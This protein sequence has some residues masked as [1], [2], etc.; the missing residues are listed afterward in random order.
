MRKLQSQ[1]AAQSNVADEQQMKGWCKNVCCKSEQTALWTHSLRPLFSLAIIFTPFISFLLP[2]WLCLYVLSQFFIFFRWFSN[3]FPDRARN[4]QPHQKCHSFPDLFSYFYCFLRYFCFFFLNFPFSTFLCVFLFRDF[5]RRCWATASRCHYLHELYM[6]IW[7]S[8]FTLQNI[9]ICCFSLNESIVWLPTTDS[10]P[11][12]VLR[13]ATLCWR[14]IL[15]Y[16]PHADGGRN[17]CWVHGNVDVWRAVSLCSLKMACWTI[18]Y[19]GYWPLEQHKCA[20]VFCF[21]RKI[22]DKP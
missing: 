19:S 16:L 21:L 10:S 6:R 5:P 1:T 14:T 13:P 22:A 4:F 11:R 7:F 12:P 3:V 15:K 2:T 18:R 9:I 8:L 20:L 17:I